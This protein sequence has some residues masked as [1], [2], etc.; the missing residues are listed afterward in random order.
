MTNVCTFLLSSL[1]GKRKNEKEGLPN[2]VNSHVRETS[3]LAY[4]KLQSE[5]A[6]NNQCDK[7]LFILS[8]NEPLTRKEIAEIIGIVP[9]SIGCAIGRLIK[10]ELIVELHKKKDTETRCLSMLLTIVNHQKGSNE[11]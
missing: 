1:Q 4:R 11:G 9:S 3:I 5:G 8:N 6:F 7:I 10:K 2:R